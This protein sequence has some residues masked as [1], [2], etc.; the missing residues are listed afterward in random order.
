MNTLTKDTK[1]V[2]GLDTFTMNMGK[3]VQVKVISKTA[4]AAGF[5]LGAEYLVKYTG[6]VSICLDF[7]Q[8][9]Y[10]LPGDT[11]KTRRGNMMRAL[12]WMA[13]KY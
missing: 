8:N 1:I 13:E 4:Q 3:V 5:W 12:E 9:W 10:L 11:F 6:D 2:P 7:G